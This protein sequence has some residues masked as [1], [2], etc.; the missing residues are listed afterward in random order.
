MVSYILV[1]RFIIFVCFSSSHVILLINLYEKLK[2]AALQKT[3]FNSYSIKENWHHQWIKIV[4]EKAQNKAKESCYPA[5]QALADVNA[6][7][8]CLF[9]TG[10]NET[11]SGIEI[12]SVRQEK[13]EWQTRTKVHLDT[14]K[15]MFH[16]GK[17]I[18]HNIAKKMAMEGSA[19][20]KLRRFL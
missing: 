11:M 18:S 2:Y 3:S 12:R 6:L 1:I 14:K 13:K 17:T 15:P 4:K 7:K 19:M 8:E 5:L 10:I 20:L 16:F 9:K